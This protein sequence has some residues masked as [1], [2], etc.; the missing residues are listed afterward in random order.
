MPALPLQAGDLVEIEGVS[1]AG[2]YAPILKG[3]EADVIGKA[4]LPSIAPRKTLT[5]LLTGAEDGQWVEVEGV[6]QAVRES[7]KNISLDLALSD[8]AITA[9]TIT[10]VGVDYHR[11]VDAKIK[12]RG[13]QA[14]LFN[15]Q[16]QMT[17]VH[18]FF[19]TRAQVTIEKP[20]PEH[21]FALPV[22]PVSRLLRFTPDSAS[23]HL[24]HIR[25]TVTLAWPGRL[26]VHSRPSPRSLRANGPDHPSERGRLSRR[27]RLSHHWRI[28]PQLDA[29]PPIRPQVT[30]GR[31]LLC[32]LPPAR[33]C[34]ATTTRSWSK[35]E[36][37]LLGTTSLQ[38]T[39]RSC[40]LRENLCSPRFWRHNPQI[41]DCPRGKRELPSK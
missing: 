12:L 23:H 27:N 22:T 37:S 15:H 31:Y 24:V 18:L 3:T 32:L 30:R 34:A 20:G 10:E 28:Y 38:V 40:W 41:S 25:G 2:D 35:S 11:P 8:G 36:A 14:P 19:P 17:G 16:L 33:L 5:E 26:L 21:P 39:R 1:A 7:G 29:A 13:N 9:N 4:P 6:V